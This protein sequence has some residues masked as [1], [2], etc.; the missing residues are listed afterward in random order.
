M[1][2]SDFNLGGRLG[3]Q[4]T[5]LKAYSSAIYPQGMSLSDSN[6]GGRLG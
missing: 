6:L 5:T 4:M 3:S 2:L 1:S